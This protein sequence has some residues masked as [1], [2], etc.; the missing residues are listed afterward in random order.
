MKPQVEG[1]GD[2][3]RGFVAGGRAGFAIDH[4]D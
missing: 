4:D 2:S 3:D 1:F